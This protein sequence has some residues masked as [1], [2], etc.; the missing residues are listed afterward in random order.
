MLVCDGVGFAG[1][2]WGW[3]AIET[4]FENGGDGG[5]GDRS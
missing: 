3:H 4:G 1:S 2:V 5:I